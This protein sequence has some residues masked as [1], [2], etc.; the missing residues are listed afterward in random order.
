MTSDAE[1][2]YGGVGGRTL[3]ALKIMIRAVVKHER[4]DLFR[5]RFQTKKP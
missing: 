2:G 1:V 4:K 3:E 5:D